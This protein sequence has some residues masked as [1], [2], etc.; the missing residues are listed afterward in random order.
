[1]RRVSAW[2]I[3]CAATLWAAAI[4][5][6]P[7]A[8][9]HGVLDEHPSLAPATALVYLTGSFICHQRPER[10]FHADGVQ[11][12]VCARCTGLY[13]GAPFGLLVALMLGRVRRRRHGRDEEAD[14]Y[15]RWRVALIAAMVPTLISVLL[16]QAGGPSDTISR[17]IAALPLGA[18]VAALAGAAVL[19]QFA[20]ANVTAAGPRAA[21]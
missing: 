9:A 16:E 18:A 19:G 8:R 2:L 17:A 5:A 3:V 11:Y 1:V 20:R 21:V 13:V 14:R 4:I 10:S 7:Y 6:V 15:R 12:P